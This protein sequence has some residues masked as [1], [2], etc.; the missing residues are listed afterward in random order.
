MEHDDAMCQVTE[1]IRFRWFGVVIVLL[2]LIVGTVHWR[3]R[4]ASPPH[5]T[6]DEE[7]S[8]LFD[9]VMSPFCPGLRLADCP[10]TGAAEL[11]AA[12]RARLAAG[13]PAAAVETQ[14]YAAFGDR[15]RSEPPARGIGLLAWIVLGLTFVAGA[16]LYVRWLAQVTHGTALPLGATAAGRGTAGATRT[17]G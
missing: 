5:R 9:R 4:P 14:L 16:A 17:T 6:A 13:E 8:A 11:R 12:I 7:A 10:S 3:V 2:V 1:S 15:I